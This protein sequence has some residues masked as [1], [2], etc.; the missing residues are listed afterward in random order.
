M[1]AEK[2]HFDLI[3]M[4]KHGDRLGSQTRSAQQRLRRNDCWMSG[5]SLL[6]DKD[7]QAGQKTAQSVRTRTRLAE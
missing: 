1:W 6:Q 5:I 2:L 7:C 3:V 4:G